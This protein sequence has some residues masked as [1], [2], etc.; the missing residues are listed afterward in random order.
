M[1]IV[2]AICAAI[3]LGLGV[4]C[5]WM[6][7]DTDLRLPPV[8]FD[9]FKFRGFLYLFLSDCVAKYDLGILYICS[10]RYTHI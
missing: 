9:L 4:L 1:Q 8:K 6:P 3:A 10:R 2:F 7:I 5:L